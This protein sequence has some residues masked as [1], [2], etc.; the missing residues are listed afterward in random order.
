MKKIILIFCLFSVFLYAKEQKLLDIKPSEG[1]YPKINDKTC[2][3]DCL[4]GLLESQMYISFLSEFNQDN[5]ELLSNIYVKLLNSITN[6]DTKINKMN[7][8]KLAII[9]PEKTIKSYSNIIINS[10]ISYLIRQRSQIKV[11]V[12]LI[13][14]ED[15]DN[16]INAINEAQNQ[17][18]DYAIAAITLK[19]IN[20]LVNYNGSL[21]IF[22]PTLHQKN[23][24]V[25]NQNIYFGSIDYDEQIKK[26]LEKS[27]SNIAAFSDNSSLSNVL[28]QKIKEQNPKRLRIYKIEDEKIDF[29]QVFKSQGSLNGASVFLNTTLI[30]TA[31][32]SSQIRFHGICVNDILSTQINYRPEFLSL[33]QANDR[34]KMIMANSINNE[35]DEIS[36]I[37]EIFNQN[38]NYNWIAYATSIGADY[39]YTNFLNKNTDKIFNEKI[40]NN[41]VIYNIKLMQPKDYNFEELK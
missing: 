15:S 26:L 28:N 37:N 6:F 20:Q 25:S 24:Q 36:Y 39:L 21:K 5:D 32:I 7:L 38:I 9:I 2:D 17:K 29:Y 12:F 33:T 8:V 4:I 22:I 18:Y 1:F 41:Q 13:G 11:K 16:V 3:Y 40:E 35:D 31:L 30:K 34:K 19:G 23:T 14:N 27:N 10:V